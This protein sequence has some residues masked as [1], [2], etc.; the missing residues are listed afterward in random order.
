MSK[1]AVLEEEQIQKFR[2]LAVIGDLHG[3]LVTLKSALRITDPNKDGIIFLGDYADRGSFGIEVIATVCSLI[4]RHPQNV[5]ALKGNHEDYRESG[6]PNFD[7]WDLEREVEEKR[8][9]WQNYFKSTFKPFVDLLSLAII[10]PGEA[11]FVHGGISSKIGNLKDLEHPTAAVEKDILWSDPVEESR[12]YIS[13]G[14]RPKFGP[15]VS[16][17]VCQRIGIKRIIRSH[18]PHRV[19]EVGGPCYSHEGR[20]ITTS[21]TTAYGRGY[22]PY[23]LS[24]SPVGFSIKCYQIGTDPP[25]ETKIVNCARK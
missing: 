20:V 6:R 7:P 8:C 1:L 25:I 5:F 15:A 2:K 4:K 22:K 11:L 16:K 9:D 24:V 3:D 10:A 18:E 23:L 12:E 19:A 13:G 14:G 21:T 17:E